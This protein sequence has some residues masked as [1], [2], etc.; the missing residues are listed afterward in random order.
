MQW[1]RRRYETKAVGHGDPTPQKAVTAAED[2][3][4]PCRPGS[5]TEFLARLGLE[6]FKFLPERLAAYTQ[7]LGGFGPVAVTDFHYTLDLFALEIGNAV[8]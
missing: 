7:H 2:M 6:V 8:L 5:F 3:E 1:A 4:H